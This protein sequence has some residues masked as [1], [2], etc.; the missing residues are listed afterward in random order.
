M[1]LSSSLKALS[2]QEILEIKRTSGKAP[3]AECKRLKL[4]CDKNIPCASCVRRG[5]G[6]TCPTGTYLPTGRGRRAVPTEASRLR[7]VLTDMEARIRDLET[8]IT[9]AHNFHLN[10]C[11]LLGISPTD[12]DRSVDQLADSLGALSVNNSGNAQYFGPTAGTEAL[13]S[14]E[15]VDDI[16]PDGVPLTFAVMTDSFSIGFQGTVAWH[17]DDALVQLLAHLPVKSRA[18][19]LLEVYFTN[20]CWSGTPIM[21]DECVELLT[22]VYDSTLGSTLPVHQLAVLYGVFALGALVDLLLPPYNAESEYYF[23]LCRAT[24]SV[25]SVFDNP[26][27]ATIQALVLVSVFYS[28]GGPKF[29][30]EGAWS[31]ISLASGL[32]KNMG[33]HSGRLQPGVTPKQLQRQRALFWETYSIETSLSLAVGRPTGTSLANIS[34]P[35]P[36]DDEQQMDDA[37]AIRHGFYHRRWEFI[38][39]VAAPVMENYLTAQP[40]SYEVI[41]ELDQRI[42]RFMAEFCTNLGPEDDRGSPAAY[43]QRRTIYQSCMIMLVYIHNHGFINAVRENPDNPYYTSHATSFLSA[44]RYASEIIRVDI[45]NFKRY[46]AL[47]SRWWPIWKSLFNAA[48]V[49]GVIAAKCPQNTYSHQ[50]LLELFVAIDL[51]ERGAA[52]SFRARGA[53][54]VLRTL[55]AKA[56][57]AYAKH[58][59]LEAAEEAASDADADATLD[60]LAGRT[61]V[62]AQNILAWHQC[63]HHAP[64]IYRPHDCSSIKTDPV[65]TLQRGLEEE[66]GGEA[67][68][69]ALSPSLVEYFS[70]PSARPEF[71]TGVAKWTRGEG[72]HAYQV[73]EGEHAYE[74]AHGGNLFD[75]PTD[76]AGGP[77]FDVGAQSAA[78]TNSNDHMQPFFSEQA[79]NPEWMDLLQNL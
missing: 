18:W 47:L 70:S 68:R 36:T 34:C 30:M 44:Y 58:S 17:P 66:N 35:L 42:R 13:L 60:V 9:S 5:C 27:T 21:R 65:Q 76:L 67:R 78:N 77:F 16:Q 71:D 4:K 10:I 1:T 37:G 49:V 40:P 39:Q 79:Y 61:R 52:S 31:V 75:I 38:K 69:A 63:A 6:D 54:S 24:L 53:L 8:A 55:R 64:K 25:I 74:G 43:T 56:I 32:C 59:G 12:K 50:A 19:A 46:P 22:L 45:D 28:H 73:E 23:D 62:V 57:A 26:S 11:P 51:F 7:R 72:E 14:I 2:Q 20:G 29:S 15:V 48:I 33:L 3:C 41:V